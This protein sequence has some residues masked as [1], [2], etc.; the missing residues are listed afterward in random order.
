M[1]DEARNRSVQAAAR[2]HRL[3]PRPQVMGA[4]PGEGNVDREALRDLPLRSQVSRSYNGRA[5]R[6][7]TAMLRARRR[8]Q[9]QEFSEA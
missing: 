8:L 2:S 5:Q 6:L 9:M 4:L 7:A 1:V 3:A